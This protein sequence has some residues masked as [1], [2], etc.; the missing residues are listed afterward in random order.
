VAWIVVSAPLLCLAAVVSERKVALEE[1]KIAH[2]ELRQFT[3]RL[4]SAQEKEKQRISRDLHDD[5]LGS[6]Q[7]HFG[8]VTASAGIKS[9]L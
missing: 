6:S 1:L 4:I 3:P 2:A 8:F 9:S 7:I 5:K